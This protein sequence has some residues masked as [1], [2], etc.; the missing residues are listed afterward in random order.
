MELNDRVS[1]IEDELKIMK[2]EVQ[3][4]L[5][6]LR[7]S[8]TNLENPFNLAAMAVAAQ[9]IIINNQPAPAAAEPAPPPEP[10]PIIP[11]E[12]VAPPEPV[13]EPQLPDPLPVEDALIASEPK[14]EPG[15]DTESFDETDP[16][17][18]YHAVATAE[19]AHEEVIREWRP[20]SE[21]EA[22][23]SAEAEVSSDEKESSSGAIDLA[24]IS[25]LANW[26][27]GVARRLGSERA[28]AILDMSKMMGFVDSELKDILV[29]FVFPTAG[30]YSGKVTTRDYLSALQE[31]DGILGRATK[32]EIALLSILCQ[33]ADNG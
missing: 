31:L 17:Y 5:L 10:E 26:V 11:P 14:A 33:G 7:E 30:E 25:A 21:A 6:D 19:T 12:P 28:E 18:E 15:G 27:E 29:K 4:V 2:N 24:M 32:F 13:V 16:E 8:Y 20:T 22:P 1:Q 3:A 23:A 9:P